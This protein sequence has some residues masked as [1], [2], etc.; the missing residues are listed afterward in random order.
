MPQSKIELRDT[1]RLNGLA[2]QAH[3]RGEWD[4]KAWLQGEVTLNKLRN[5][6][7]VAHPLQAGQDDIAKALIDEA[8]DR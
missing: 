4:E 8:M 2:M 7:D 6:L 5:L 3:R 1:Q